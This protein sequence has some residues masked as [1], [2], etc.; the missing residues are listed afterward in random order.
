M[1]QGIVFPL[2]LGK[3]TDDGATPWGSEMG[4]GTPEQRLKFMIDSGTDNTWVT[5]KAC[6]TNACLAHGRFNAEQSA[7]Y[8]V[9]DPKPV[10]KDFGP[11]GTMTVVMG[12]D[13]FTLVR[14]DRNLVKTQEKMHFEAAIHYTGCRFQELACD[15]GVAIPSPYWKKQGVTEAL[16]LQLIKDGK[17]EK[18]LASFWMDTA[19]AVGECTFGFDDARRYKPETLQWL[20]LQDMSGSSLDYLWSVKLDAFL[21]DGEKAEA[22]MGNFVLDS[23]SSFFKGPSDLID[24][25]V[26]VVTRN[27]ALPTYVSSEKALDAYPEISLLLGG[28]RY[29]LVPRQ[30]FLKLNEEYWE[31]GIQT[32]AGMPDGMLLVGSIFLDTVYTIFDY[33]EKRIGLAE[34]N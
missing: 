12:A 3:L 11:W 2:T 7:S 21:V 6:T 16:M 10:Q 5:A 9:L 28:R 32:L 23:G 26:R 20:S 13:V 8:E 15:G 24:S 33:G 29:P 30:Y 4:L 27:G 22:T 17:I 1:S 25:L 31:L 19:K 14:A 18:P 34:R